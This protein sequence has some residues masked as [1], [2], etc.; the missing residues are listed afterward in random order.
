MEDIKEHL[1]LL[2]V[3]RIVVYTLA[4]M[5]VFEGI[6]VLLRFGFNL[7]SERSFHFISN[8]TFGIRVHHGYF[9]IVLLVI[10]LAF[11]GQGAVKNI[12]IIIG[13]A[14][15]FSDIIHHFLVL[16]PITGSPEFHLMYPPRE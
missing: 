3:N 4:L 8:I 12:L 5:L 2:T 13:G 11:L 1:A 14:L 10:A 7:Q 9:G 6:T 16:W 15:L